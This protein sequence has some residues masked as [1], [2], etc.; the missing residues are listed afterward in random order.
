YYEA[1]I[2]DVTLEQGTYTLLKE[3]TVNQQALLD[4]SSQYIGSGNACLPDL[5]AAF[6]LPLTEDC[7]VDCES[8]VEDLGTLQDFMDRVADAAGGSVPSGQDA[9]YE[10]LYDELLDACK[11]PCRLLTNCKVYHQLLEGDMRPG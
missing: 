1:N 2:L 7:E 5:E 9:Y 11:E 8:C 6:T 4:Y 3:L 10:N